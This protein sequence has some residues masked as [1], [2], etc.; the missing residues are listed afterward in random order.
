MVFWKKHNKKNKKVAQQPTKACEPAEPVVI[1]RYVDTNGNVIKNTEELN[2]FVLI[3]IESLS[4]TDDFMKYQPE[5]RIE[6]NL[7]PPMRLSE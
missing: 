3:D 1:T 6:K 5:T 4:L 2:S 7:K